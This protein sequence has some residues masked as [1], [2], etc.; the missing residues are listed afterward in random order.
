MSLSTQ[1]GSWP[2]D[3]LRGLA[4]QRRVLVALSVRQL[5]TKYGR[6]NIGFLWIV[7][8]PMILCAGVLVVR[9]IISAGEENG[10]SLIG[11]L[12][13]GYIPL[14]L[15]RHI[16]NAGVNMLRQCANLLYHRD[17]SLLDCFGSNLTIEIGGC[18]IAGA[19]V[20][21]V[22]YSL[23][24]IEPIY[25]IGLLLAGWLELA[26]VS[27]SVMVLFAVMTAIWEW[28]DRFIQPFQYLLL[29]LCG[30]FYMV[31]WLPSYAQ[32]MAVWMPTVNTYEMIRAGLWGPTVTTHYM[33]W[34]PI[35]F[36]LVLFAIA[37][38]LVDSARNKIH[39]G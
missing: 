22:I 28:S 8:E 18:T 25:D 29:P 33:W 36:G 4:V 31:E 11:M 16:S 3:T 2:V 9:S 13:T 10:V 14:T 37:L 39:F 38:P 23:G 20:Y 5:M 26:F 12:W 7:L 15:W 24:C 19:L 21:W 30:F 35:L 17:I 34:Y 32:K 6:N 1:P 27:A